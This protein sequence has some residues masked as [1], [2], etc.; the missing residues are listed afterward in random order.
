MNPLSS[1]QFIAKSTK[2]EKTKPTIVTSPESIKSGFNAYLQDESRLVGEPTDALS[3]PKDSFELEEILKNSRNSDIFVSGA[4]TGVTGGAVPCP[5]HNGRKSTLISL[6]KL[7]QIESPVIESPDTAFIWIGSG[8]S[9]IQLEEYL[10]ENLP[11]YYFPVDPTERWA[12]FGGMAATNASGARSFRFGSVRNWISAIECF[13]VDG[14]RFILER[15]KHK[16]DGL[17]F[18]INNKQF[19]FSKIPKPKTKNSIGYHYHPDMSLVDLMIGSEGT[20]SIFS[21]LKIQLLKRPF[22]ILSLL[23]F[24]DNN[25]QALAFV[26]SVREKNN[27][28]TLSLEFMDKRSIEFGLSGKVRFGNQIENIL[29]SKNGAAVYTEFSYDENSDSELSDII[30]CIE[31]CLSRVSASLEDGIC[32]TTDSEIQQMK[33]FR[34]AIP[35]S[36]NSVVA[37]R[38]KQIPLLRKV[39]T[40]MAVP[41]EH[42]EDVFKTYNNHLQKAGLD[43]AIFGHAGDNHFHVNILPSSE[44]ELNKALEVYKV[45]AK[46]ISD[47]LN[48]SV[49]AEHGI[50]RIKKEFLRVQYPESV[51][52]NMKNIK[53]AFDPD[54]RLNP[55]VLIDR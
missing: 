29:K 6:E 22:Q 15:D 4:R 36:I 54:F 10:L 11:R 21:K 46:E 7:N 16:L 18:E 25:D 44:L 48:G 9:L 30:N 5:L 40:D 27:S 26:R 49:A 13:S 39:A 38:K 32:G 1:I 50:G 35:E 14:E 37:E 23:Q 52:Q 19:T 12:S 28:K 51:I 3:Q 24:F 42:L 20:L 45:I 47:R 33:Q 17:A 8:V 2:A 31:T 34:H 43:Y 41:D 55:G 53:S